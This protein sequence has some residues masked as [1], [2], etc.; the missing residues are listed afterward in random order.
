MSEKARGLDASYGISDKANAGWRG[1]TSYFEKALETPT[2]QRLASFYTQGDKQVRDI[3]AEALR[4]AN[5]RNG[6]NSDAAT[7]A[8]N[9]K[10][11][12]KIPGTEHTTCNC[13]GNDG[14]CAC[15]AGNCACSGCAKS[16]VTGEK[17]A[18]GPA[19]EVAASSTVA[20]LGEKSL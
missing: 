19:D 9:E 17:S 8:E 13:A 1:M 3:H 5:L 15:S 11:L 6:K 2:G 16:D 7:K 12:K 18:T 10:S 4:L 20:P 14:V